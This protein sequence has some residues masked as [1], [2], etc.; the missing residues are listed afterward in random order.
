M[1]GDHACVVVARVDLRKL[2]NRQ[3]ERAQHEGPHGQPAA[4]GAVPGV[5]LRAQRLQLARQASADLS[6]TLAS[7]AFLRTDSMPL[8]RADS[9]E[10]ISLM[11]TTWPLVALSV[12]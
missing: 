6:S 3:H 7:G 12:K 11:P 10:Y 2:A 1:A 9:D 5:E 4:P 8:S